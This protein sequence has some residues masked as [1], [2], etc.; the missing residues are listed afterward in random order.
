VSAAARHVAAVAFKLVDGWKDYG[1]L[2][3]VEPWHRVAMRCHACKTKWLGCWDN[4]Q[5]PE[6]GRGELP[7]AAPLAPIT[8]SSV[9]IGV[10]ADESEMVCVRYL[11]DERQV[12]TRLGDFLDA[13]VHEMTDAEVDALYAGELVTIV[14]RLMGPY[15]VAVIR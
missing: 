11:E 13:N 3:A 15:T 5:C 8:P 2:S 7:G 9:K 4:F 14:S 12:E 6:C 10:K 1:D